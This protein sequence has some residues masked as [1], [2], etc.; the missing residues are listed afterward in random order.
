MAQ[1]QIDYRKSL[2]SALRNYKLAD[3]LIDSIHDLQVFVA[4]NGGSIDTQI[5]SSAI[6]RS[7]KSP[8]QLVNN[9]NIGGEG[10]ASYRRVLRSALANRKLAD[11]MLNILTELQGYTETA[12]KQQTSIACIAEGSVK[13]ITSI[14][15]VADVAGSLD[16]TYFV[17]Q[18]DAGSVAF[19]IDVDDSG[20]AEPAHGADRPVEITTVTTG[21]SAADVGTAVYNAIIGDSKFEAGSDDLAGNLLVQSST[22]GVKTDGVDGDTGFTITESVPGVDSVLDGKVFILEDVDGTVGFWFDV[23]DSGTTIPAEATAADRPVEITT[24]TSG[25]SAADVGTAVYTAVV[26]DSKFEAG[27]D[28]LAGGLVIQNVDTGYYAN[29]SASTSGFTVA[30]SDAGSAAAEQDELSLQQVTP[31]NVPYTT[32]NLRALTSALNHATLASDILAM[33]LEL[34]TEFRDNKLGTCDGTLTNDL[35]A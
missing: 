15:T 24:I 29:V 22:Y 4:A 28:D 19:W 26:A 14:I 18:D 12:G 34:Q 9:D 3:A 16:G 20:T 33:I 6:T 11:Q 17:L 23:D 2:H 8:Y 1:H 27:S 13:E 25:M 7:T 35:I 32:A 5:V 10:I 30:V 21:M 31:G